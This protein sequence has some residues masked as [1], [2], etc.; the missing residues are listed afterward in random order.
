MRQRV[1]CLDFLICYPCLRKPLFAGASQVG[2]RTVRI[3]LERRLY[4]RGAKILLSNESFELAP[5]ST[6]NWRCAL[7]HMPWMGLDRSGWKK[8]LKYYWFGCILAPVFSVVSRAASYKGCEY[9]QYST[10]LYVNYLYSN[11]FHVF[12]RHN[13]CILYQR[14]WRLSA[15]HHQNG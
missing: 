14:W 2:G 5:S 8:T 7:G 1:V 6:N 4:S 3:T 10:A 12:H 13:L 11:F 15:S 9:L